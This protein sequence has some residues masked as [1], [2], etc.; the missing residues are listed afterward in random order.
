V[1]HSLPLEETHR[2]RKLYDGF[3]NIR[4][5]YLTKEEMKTEMRANVPIETLF[6]RFYERQTGGAKPTAELVQL[7]LELLV[8]EDEDGDEQ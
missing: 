3:V 7:F 8:D 2:L 6:E 4:P 1:E 5:N